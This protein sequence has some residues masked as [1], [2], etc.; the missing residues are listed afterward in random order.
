M[1]P[2]LSS[3]LRA[4]R[5]AAKAS[6][7]KP[8]SSKKKSTKTENRADTADAAG[9]GGKG[10]WARG[11]LLAVLPLQASLVVLLRA[12][13]ALSLPPDAPHTPYAGAGELLA[14]SGVAA[15][16][17]DV[18]ALLEGGGEGACWAR[19][20]PAAL[21][22]ALMTAAYRPASHPGGNPRANQ[23]FFL[24]PPIQIPPE[25]GGI[26]G[27]LTQALPLGFLQ[28]RSAWRS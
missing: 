22:P 2:L 28:R 14:L 7:R 16:L 1:G 17:A 19:L 26:C 24:S 25:S 20:R 18:I 9:G 8:S 5:K 6:P 4:L 11:V 10:A 3:A 23:C 21:G 15:S 27:R 13:P 12:T